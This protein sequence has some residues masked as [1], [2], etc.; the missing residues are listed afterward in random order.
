M[1]GMTENEQMGASEDNRPQD[2]IPAG[3]HQTE[4][5]AFPVVGIGASAGGLEAMTELLEHLDANSGMAFVLI[6]HLS[7]KQTT[8]LPE[9]LARATSMPVLLAENEMQVQPNHL[10]IIP[11]G[12]DMTIYHGHLNL[13]E[14][15]SV[16][17]R[18]LPIDYFLRSLAL[19]QQ[20]RAIGIILSGSASDGALGLTAIK[21]EGAS[22]SPRTRGRRA[23]RAC[24]WPPSGP[25]GS[26]S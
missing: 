7:P 16:S 14:R 17:G 5:T 6:Q 11:P 18:H 22:P 20:R 19:D 8:I 2:R 24:P 3:E 23:T 10:Y 4:K 13:M 25:A 26:M 9:I 15:T 12:R 1:R 21:A